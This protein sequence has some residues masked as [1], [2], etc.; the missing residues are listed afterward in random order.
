VGAINTS[1][2]QS[3]ADRL[4]VDFLKIGLSSHIVQIDQIKCERMWGDA[5][6]YD[7]LL[8]SFYP[9]SFEFSIMI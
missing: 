4:T 5:R 3:N 8:Q 9:E 2:D 7:S 1:V 6:Q